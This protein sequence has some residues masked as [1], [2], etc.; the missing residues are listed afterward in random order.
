MTDV[1]E[2]LAQATRTLDAAG[3]DAA[4][5]DA[6]L[7]LAHCLNV[8]RTRLAVLDRVGPE[9]GARF[10][11]LV[12]QR[13][14]RV[15]LQHITGTAPFRYLDL[16][17]GP[18]V[19]IPRPETELLVDAALAA[20]AGIDRP[21]VVDLCAGS[22]AIALSVAHECPDAEV[23]AVERSESA[24]TW[25]RRNAAG[26]GAR[27]V[28]ADVTEPGLLAELDG[29]VDAVVSNPPY[30]PEAA[31]VSAE[32]NHDPREAVFA[33]P[34]GLEVIADVLTVAARLLRPGG[35]LAIEHD[36]SHRTAVPQL[37]TATGDWSDISDHDD[38]SG[39]PR[40]VTARRVR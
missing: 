36:D 2:L 3:V 31:P 7:L 27:V 8:S 39:R 30:V 17:V 33:G 37:L 32:V 19:F 1:R 35:F 26:T 4:R 6:E 5:V 10:Q 20:I 25:L 34:D 24:L 18:G 38:L 22:G 21:V 29:G 15:P 11:T 23:F 16:A 40:F 9:A 28:A 12:E 14:R 13:A